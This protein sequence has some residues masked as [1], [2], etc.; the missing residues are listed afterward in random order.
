MGRMLTDS[1]VEQYRDRGY[2]FP[3]TVLHEDE[4]SRLRAKLEAFESAQGHPI[5]GAQRRLFKGA[6]RV[7]KT[8]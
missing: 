4:V 8:L 5:E 2:Y 3:V 7:R 6:E 1:A